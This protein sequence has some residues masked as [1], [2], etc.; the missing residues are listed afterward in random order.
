MFV[1]APGYT[2]DHLHFQMFVFFILC[3]SRREYLQTEAP[4]SLSKCVHSLICPFIYMS[5]QALV[6]LL[7]LCQVLH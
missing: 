1:D 7:T 4:E 6:E 2:F 3:Q 5:G